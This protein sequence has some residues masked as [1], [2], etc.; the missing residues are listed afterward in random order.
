VEEASLAAASAAV[1]G[2]SLY[3]RSRAGMKLLTPGARKIFYFPMKNRCLLPKTWRVLRKTRHVF[4]V[5][6]RGTSE[7]KK[8]YVCRVSAISFLRVRA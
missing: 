7:S 3:A 4:F 8:F 6:G 1:L 2:S 5:P